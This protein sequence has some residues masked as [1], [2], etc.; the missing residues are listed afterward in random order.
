MQMKQASTKF[1]CSEIIVYVWP[2]EVMVVT[3]N[4]RKTHKRLRK[5]GETFVGGSWISG[6]DER[7]EE[8]RVAEGEELHGTCRSNNEH[9]LI[10]K[11]CRALVPYSFYIQ[12][13]RKERCS[14]F[15]S[16]LQFNPLSFCIF[17]LEP[18][19]LLCYQILILSC[20]DSKV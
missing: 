5:K 15:F 13:N 8:K 10:K 9:E 20:F 12:G 7:Q 11:T 4:E 18:Q 19:G 3:C 1:S 2:D 6:G 14:L 17:Q 16:C